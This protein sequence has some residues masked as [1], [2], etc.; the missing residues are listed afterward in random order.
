MKVSEIITGLLS[1]ELSN[2]YLSALESSELNTKM[3]LWINQALRDINLRVPIIQKSH[4][5]SLVDDSIDN[6]FT[7][8]APP[9]YIGLLSAWNELGKP[10]SINS[11]T[12]PLSIFTAEQMKIIIPYSTVGAKISIVYQANPQILV[13]VDEDL[14][15][16]QQFESIIT[17]YIAVK[18]LAGLETQG[19]P[20]NLTYEQRYEKAISLLITS[21]MYNPDPIQD[22]T[23]FERGGWK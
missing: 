3:L 6:G 19:K 5:Y 15:V 10:V 18:A 4:I 2:T 8:L 11:S 12:D 17:N 22:V 16:G 14:P 23:P 13:N 1:S 20:V 21:G 9:D 7:Y